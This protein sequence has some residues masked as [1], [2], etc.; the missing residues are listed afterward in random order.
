MK[1]LIVAGAV[2]ALIGAACGDDTAET[3]TT[4]PAPSTTVMATTTTPT[5]TATSTTT[6]TTSTTIITTTAAPT[7]TTTTTLPP[8]PDPNDW[9]GTGY[10]GM[11][12]DGLQL[13][14]T[15]CVGI[16]YICDY[17]LAITT[18][19]GVLPQVPP[20][21]GPIDFIALLAS[22]DANNDPLI[23]DAATI[24]GLGTD[25]VWSECWTTA[26]NVYVVGVWDRV[27]G[28]IGAFRWDVTTE[29]VWVIQGSE[30]ATCW[31]P[32]DNE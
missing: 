8:P 3:T 21:E 27:T 32:M 11:A 30:V 25:L 29:D 12:P 31:D 10:T 13:L 17:T 22:R 4:T 1:R 19:D 20:F 23:V 24:R 18:L 7:T 16:D 9:I 6:T 14:Q 2:L 26:G 15:E 28:V 5:T